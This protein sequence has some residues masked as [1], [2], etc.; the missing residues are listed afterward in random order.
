M[1]ESLTLTINEIR[2]LAMLAGFEVKNYT[3]DGD[4]EITI[5]TCPEKGVDDD[6]KIIQSR[7]IAYFE[8]YPEEGVL[9]LGRP[10]NMTTTKP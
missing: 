4:Y 2:D 7:Y 5:E 1:K 9:P 6:G 10:L 3:E 8:D